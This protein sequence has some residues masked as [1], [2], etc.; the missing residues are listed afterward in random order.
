MIPPRR[1]VLS[2][3]GVKVTSLLGSLRVLEEAKY[4]RNVKEI[5]GVSA[6]AFLGFLVAT[7]CQLAKIESFMLELDFSVIRNINPEAFIGFPETFG[8]DDGANLAKLLKSLFHRLVHIDPEITFGNFAPLAKYSFRC[9]A[10]D[11][12]TNTIREFSARATPTVKIID[13]LRASMCLPLYFIPF[14]DPLTGHLLTDGGIQGNLPLQHLTDDECQESLA[15]GFSRKE[16]ASDEAPS[17]LM[18]FMYSVLSC[19]VH[20][21]NENCLKK[22]NHRIIQ[23]PVDEI[24]SWNFEISRETRMVL[25]KVGKETTREWL[26]KDSTG[27]NRILRRHSL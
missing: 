24:A 27:S 12:N 8:L 16:N 17:D 22:W 18:G 15:L 4:L 19:L 23:I 25:L 14:P 13:A 20:S 11:L 1:I 2:G 26:S 3:G 6:G 7:G 9:W 21:R 10:T 5:C